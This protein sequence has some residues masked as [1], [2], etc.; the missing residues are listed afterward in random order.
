MNAAMSKKR[1][2]ADLIKAQMDIWIATAV[3]GNRDCA[4][5]QAP[6][7][8][9]LSVPEDGCNWTVEYVKAPAQCQAIMHEIIARA[10]RE[11]D[12]AV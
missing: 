10:R 4:G 3:D 9:A 6:R 7:P 11:Y 5:C 12:L 2:T 8:I 1:A